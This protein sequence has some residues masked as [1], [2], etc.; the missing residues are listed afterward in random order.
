[1][2]IPTVFVDP[3]GLAS[4]SS[5]NPV[6]K[7]QQSSNLP[8][9]DRIVDDAN[10]VAAPGGTITPEQAQILRDNLPVVQRRSTF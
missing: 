1:M 4:Y 8:L 7:N 5:N 6:T 3:L 10:K 9:I 2:G